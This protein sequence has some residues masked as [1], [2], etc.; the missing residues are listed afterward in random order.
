MRIA[1]KVS[2]SL[3]AATAVG[4]GFVSWGLASAAG[5]TPAQAVAAGP[6]LSASESAG[7]TLSREEERM[8]RELYTLFAGKYDAAPF[9][10]IAA[11]EQRHYNAV[12]VLLVRYGVKDPSAASTAGVYTDATI[13]KLYNDWKASGS[14]S[15]AAAYRVGVALEKRDIADLKRLQ[16]ATTK[17]DL[18]RLYGNLESASEHHLAA[19]TAAAEGKAL[20]AG[21]PAADG[22]RHGRG[23][24][25]GS[26]MGPGT[27]NGAGMG[28]RPGNGAGMGPR[29]GQGCLT[30]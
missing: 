29:G 5:G 16:D 13:Q 18:D 3:A 28:P 22:Q 20:P 21:G 26:G 27:G 2:L 8:A 30:S 4:V 15:A 17:T 12:G 11:S 24:G 14:T 25:N 1:R 10:Q 19:F 9:A 7:L 23:M 6:S